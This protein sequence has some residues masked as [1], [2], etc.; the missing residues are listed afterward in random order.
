MM[1]TVLFSM[2]AVLA[3]SAL[4][5]QTIRGRV[6]YPNGAPYAGATAVAVDASNRRT[7]VAYADRDGWFYIHRVQ[8]GNYTVTVQTP[9][10]KR[11]VAV[12]VTAAEYADVAPLK[13]Q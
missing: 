1:R 2:I 13:M 4:E 9:N 12:A 10:A 5:A 7:T 8:P 3:A 6:V 11:N